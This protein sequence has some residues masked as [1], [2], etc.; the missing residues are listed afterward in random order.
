[1][2]AT[3]GAGRPAVFLD[4]DGVLVVPEMREGRSFAP[5]SLEAY[6]LYESARENLERLRDAGFA[7]VVVTNQPDV[8]SGIVP[9]SLVETMHRRLCAELPIDAVKVCYHTRA[10]DCSCRKPRPGMLIEAARQLGVS[11]DRSFMIGDR[12]SD[13]AAGNAVGCRTIF[14]DLG[15]AAET[16]PVD[17]TLTVKSLREATDVILSLTRP[18]GD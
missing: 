7:L 8:G 17:A 2:V 10:D 12:A 18:E 3:A 6:R 5:R 14:I 15:Y 4:R 16:K 9:Q 11:C 13:V 1:M